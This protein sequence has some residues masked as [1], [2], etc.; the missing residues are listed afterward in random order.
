MIEREDLFN[1][2]IHKK[3]GRFIKNIINLV[4]CLKLF[5]ENISTRWRKID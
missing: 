4:N 1:L 5:K 2:I 3:Y